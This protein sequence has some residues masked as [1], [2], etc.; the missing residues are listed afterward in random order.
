[1][2]R[3]YEVWRYLTYQEQTAN[4][5]VLD[6]RQIRL[7]FEFGQNNSLVATVRASVTNHDQ[8]I[9]MALR[10]KTKRGFSKDLA[11]RRL[12]VSPS[13][14]HGRDLHGIGD[15]VSV[16]DHHTFLQ[17]IRTTLPEIFASYLLEGPRFHW[18]SRGT[19]FDGRPHQGPISAGPTW[20][21][22]WPR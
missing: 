1:M 3:L 4:V 16:G 19:Q 12:F 20:A 13:L 6:R 14:L 21:T 7:D 9:D 11:A 8:R 17:N 2:S 5:E 10:E 18:N 15:D 22:I